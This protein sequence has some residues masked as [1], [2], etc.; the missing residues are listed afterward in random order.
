MTLDEALLRLREGKLKGNEIVITIDDGFYSV[1]ALAVPILQKMGFTATIYVTTYYV[2]HKNP[3][4]RLV[5]QYIF[6]KTSL[7]KLLLNDLVVGMEAAVG[8]TKGAE[9]EQTAGSIIEFG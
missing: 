9:G 1:Y 7:K 8:T 6:W 3:I 2:T 4:F 5:I